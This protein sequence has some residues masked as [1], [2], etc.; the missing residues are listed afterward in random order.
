MSA[1]RL[2]RSPTAA[3]ARVAPWLIAGIAAAVFANALANG[4][5]FDD[6]GVILNNPLVHRTDGF[7][8]A[9][10]APY[11]PGGA[12]QYRPLVVA[13]FSIEWQLWGSDPRGFHA[14]NVAWHA[15][16]SVLV[17]ALARRWLSVAGSAMAAALFAVHPVHV[18][19]VANVVGRAELMAAAGV[20]A[21]LLLHERRSRWAIVAFAAALLSKEHAIVA[22]L[23]ALLADLARV[24][25]TALSARVRAL[26]HEA[27]PLFA[28]YAAVVF[29][30]AAAVAAVF[31]AR[32]FAATD[33]VWAVVDAPTRWLTML[34][35]VPHWVRLWFAPAALS[36]DYSPQVVAVW[37]GNL[38][39]AALGAV[40]LLAGLVGAVVACRRNAAIAAGC[41][42]LAVTMLPVANL[43][44][45]TGV[46]LAERTL[47]LSSIGAVVVVA[48]IAERAAQRTALTALAV[49]GVLMLAGAAR[50]WTRTPVWASNRSVLVTT[51]AE[52]P[53]ASWTHVLLGRVYAGNGGYREALAE[54]RRAVTL[55]PLNATAWAE[56]V[57][58]AVSAGEPAT[59]DS[60][61]VAARVHV[62]PTY[63]LRVAEVLVA[64][65]LTR[66]R[67]ALSLVR[68]VLATS[69]DSAAPRLLEGIA[70]AGLGAPDSARASL[71]RI[72]RSHP[73]RPRA[74]S[75]VRALDATGRTPE[76]P[77]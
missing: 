25:G 15:L 69:P 16:V 21:T 68:G 23:L 77:Q 28:G 7:W 4:F 20:L 19:A 27:W 49:V 35:V 72:P 76:A 47:Y 8:R 12:G 32:P 64:I 9:F 73:V 44:L 30:W 3:L 66:F 60:L 13:S 61:L 1:I 37:P 36:A 18:E 11:W 43:I 46:I 67:D 26:R 58:A 63:S 31:A 75:L 48:A 42:W 29:S 39:E 14:L 24:P 74:D 2:P 54:Y 65:E 50:T 10:L 55:N 40:L 59:A 56:A 71:A 45:P 5:A 52:R 6:E 53:E 70:W 62:R 17:F 34:G 38:G 51:S 22:P 33:P 41:V 57:Q